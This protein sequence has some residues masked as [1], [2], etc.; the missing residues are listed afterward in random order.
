M[1]FREKTDEHEY[2]LG[3]NTF[4]F[5]AKQRKIYMAAPTDRDNI[6]SYP[7]VADKIYHTTTKHITCSRL[8]DTI[9]LANNVCLGQTLHAK[10]N[11]D[12]NLTLQE[13]LLA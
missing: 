9:L 4:L 8:F 5:Y 6:A 10:Q 3:M 2:L 1:H 12:F 11:L 13:T 7:L